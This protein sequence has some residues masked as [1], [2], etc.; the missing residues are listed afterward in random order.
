MNLIADLYSTLKGRERPEDI[1]RRIVDS[2]EFLN[3]GLDRTARKLLERG[4]DAARRYGSYMAQ[5][6]EQASNLGRQID[7][8]K[9][10]FAGVAAPDE[11]NDAQAVH[12]YLARLVYALRIE[13]HDFL[14][15]RA[16][17]AQRRALNVET[18]ATGHRAYNKR[19][20]LLA[21]MAA[22]LK[23]WE[24][25][26][27]RRELAQCAKSRL[28]TRIKIDELTDP[29]S[30]CFVAY[31][32]A[33]SNVRSVFTSG[34][35]DRA[36]DDVC[37]ALFRQL[38][39]EKANWLAIAHVHVDPDVL[40]HLDDTAKGRLLAAWFG[41]MERA[42][43]ILAEQTRKGGLELG[44]MIVRRGNDSS[45]WN[46]AAGAFSKAR[47]GW[48]STLHALGADALLDEFAPGKALR[49]MAADVAW[50]HRR[51]GD[52]L[53]PDTRVWNALPKPW[54]VVL[55]RA[56]CDRS[57]IET[58]CRGAGVEG[59]GWIAPRPKS[60]AKWRPAPELVYGVEVGSPVFGAILKKLGFFAGPSKA[61]SVTPTVNVN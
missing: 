14:A 8:A 57:M 35:Q 40:A 11:A 43:R 38:D 4:A 59:R 46:E 49:L 56:H 44:S 34:K 36:F 45:T 53:D 5:S 30:A 27:D 22:K 19:F 31:F 12:D 21:R 29:L 61:K 47:D 41:V 42:A 16:T 50:L 32:T 26:L 51:N 10:L 7:V 24:Q 18:V 20:R 9:A 1:A 28:A 55:G 25:N 17:R 37:D 3:I 60:V 6:F 13:G 48:I 15:H 2:P 33:R 54:E 39:P 23:A 58:A 52:G